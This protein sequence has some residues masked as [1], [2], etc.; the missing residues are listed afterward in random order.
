MSG[1][2]T[3]I[4]DGRGNFKFDKL[5]PGIYV[6]VETDPSGYVST[7]PNILTVVLRNNATASGIDFGDY[8]PPQ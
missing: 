1:A 8:Q 6:V 4:T 5:P 7:S 2:G 3:R